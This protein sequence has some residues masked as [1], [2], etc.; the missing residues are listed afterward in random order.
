MYE[1][2]DKFVRTEDRLALETFITACEEQGIGWAGGSR[3]SSDIEGVRYIECTEL[4][5]TPWYMM[6]PVSIEEYLEDDSKEFEM[7]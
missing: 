5:F 1:V 3:D 4:A 6:F 7:F 2:R